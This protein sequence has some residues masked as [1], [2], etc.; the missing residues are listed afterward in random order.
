MPVSSAA[1]HH[2]TPLDTRFEPVSL[3]DMFERTW[4]RNKSAPFLHFLGRTYTYSDIYVQ[5]CCFAAGLQETLGIQKGDRV[6]L[7]LPNVP[8]LRCRLLR[9]DDGG[10]GGGQFSRRSIAVEELNWQ[11]GD[12]GT[13]GCCVDAGCAR[14]FYQN[15]RKVLDGSAL[16]DAGGGQSF[17]NAAVV[18]GDGAQAAE[19]A[20]RFVRRGLRPDDQALGRQ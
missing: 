18:Q 3:P 5:A 17:R 10:R 2:P 16:G 8:I 20:R 4:R 12:S 1:Y 15:A 14:I 6:G 9:G 11:V 19:A 7:F 13:R